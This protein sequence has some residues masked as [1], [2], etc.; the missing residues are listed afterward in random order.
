MTALSTFELIKKIEGG[1]QPAADS[2][3]DDKAYTNLREWLELHQA[4]TDELITAADSDSLKCYASADKI[5]SRAR[6]HLKDIRDEID[7][8]LLKWGVIDE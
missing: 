6:Q 1:I 7:V 5:I 4:V 8:Y 3:L 2:Y